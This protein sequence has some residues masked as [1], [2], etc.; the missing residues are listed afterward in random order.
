MTERKNPSLLIFMMNLHCID[1]G[2][3]EYAQ[4]LSWQEELVRQ[5]CQGESEDTLLLL[6]RV[7]TFA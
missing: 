6:E 5:R 2:L 1:L 7:L 4:A 3:V